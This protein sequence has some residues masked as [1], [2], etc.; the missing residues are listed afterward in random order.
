MDRKHLAQCTVHSKCPVA[1]TAAGTGV[2]HP[3]SSEKESFQEKGPE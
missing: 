3:L 2:P 1:G